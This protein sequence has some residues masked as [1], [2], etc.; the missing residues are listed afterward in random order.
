MGC[1]PVPKDQT[2]M[3]RDGVLCTRCGLDSVFPFVSWCRGSASRW[4]VV[5]SDLHV[6]QPS[7]GWP[8]PPLGTL[9]LLLS[10]RAVPCYTVPC[11]LDDTVH[12]QR[13]YRLWFL[14]SIVLV[15]PYGSKGLSSCCWCCLHKT[16]VLVGG[17]IGACLGANVLVV[18]VLF[19]RRRYFGGLWSF[20]T[21]SDCGGE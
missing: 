8:V 5:T 11:C 16:A 1:V 12:Y 14:S 18:F 3:L 20:F 4:A 19:L 10:S 2:A 21:A 9:H 6:N 7:S 17:Q 13:R 15:A